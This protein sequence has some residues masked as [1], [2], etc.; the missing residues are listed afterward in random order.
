MAVKKKLK[1]ESVE[2]ALKDIE[3]EIKSTGLDNAEPEAPK[4]SKRNRGES[5][6][7]PNPNKGGRELEAELE[8]GM[9]NTRKESSKKD[10]DDE[11]TVIK[12]SK[13]KGSK[14]STNEEDSNMAVKKKKSEKKAARKGNGATKGGDGFTASDLARELK[15]A[16]AE[17]RK[18]LRDIKAKKPGGSWIWASAKDE[19]LTKIRKALKEH[20]KS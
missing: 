8:D 1:E 19:A 9:K 17:L 10:P 5:M 4:E 12:L 11:H 7:S 20:F 16:P 13:K 18:A 2:E 3:Q 6:K 14:S 15:V